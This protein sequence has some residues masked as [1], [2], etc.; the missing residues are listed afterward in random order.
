MTETLSRIRP[1]TWLYPVA[2]IIFGIMTLTEGGITLRTVPLTE[3]AARSIVPTILYFNFASGFVY[4]VIALWA[5]KTP[6]NARLAAIGLASAILV[7]GI[8]LAVHASMG[9]N[10]MPRTAWAMLSRFLFWA[11]FVFW[12]GRLRDR[13]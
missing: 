13:A 12:A 1:R 11:G 6:H 3:M 8:Y 4:I 2:A 7:M 5:L 10:F 9:G